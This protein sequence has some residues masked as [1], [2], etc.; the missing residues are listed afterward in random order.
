MVV[1]NSEQKGVRIKHLPLLLHKKRLV[2]RPHK[3]TRAR[4]V[5]EITKTPALEE[6]KWQNKTTWSTSKQNYKLYV[7][8]GGAEDGGTEGE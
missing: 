3:V 5:S 2:L 1:K 8:A 6:E 4:G 7:V